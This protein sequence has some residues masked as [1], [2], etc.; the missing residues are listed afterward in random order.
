M[1][2]IVD[3][4]SPTS[5]DVVG[6]SFMTPY[7][8]YAKQLAKKVQAL[9]AL[10]VVVGTH[11]IILP[12]N[13]KPF[14]DDIIRRAGEGAM[15]NLLESVRKGNLPEK[16]VFREDDDFWFN[17]D[18]DKFPHPRYGDIEDNIIMDGHL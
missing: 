2:G 4:F 8:D 3:D 15:L 18:V 10:V 17:E 6:I 12:D 16:G 14:A 5:S 9:G 1:D 13:C 11:P 7:R